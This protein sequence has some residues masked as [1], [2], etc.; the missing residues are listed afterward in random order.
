MTQGNPLKTPRRALVVICLNISALLHAGTPGETVSDV[1][2]NEY[3]TVEIGGRLWMRDNL[4]AENTAVGEP[5]GGA[6]YENE[7]ANCD[8]F[9]R[10]YTWYEIMNGSSEACAQGICP[11]GWHV[12][13]DEEW[14]ELEVALGVSPREADWSNSWRG[15]DQGTRMSVGG[16]S[17]FDF[18]EAGRSEGDGYFGWKHGTAYFWTSTEYADD[19]SKAWRRCLSNSK[20]TIGRWNTFPKTYGF[21]LRC[22]KDVEFDAAYVV[23]RV[24]ARCRLITS[25]HAD[26]HIVKKNPCNVM[27]NDGEYYFFAPESAVVKIDTATFTTFDKRGCE[28][29]LEAF[30][31]LAAPVLSAEPLKRMLESG[32][33][34]KDSA[35]DTVALSLTSGDITYE[36]F[37]EKHRW[38]VTSIRCSGGMDFQADYYYDYLQGIPTLRMVALEGDTTLSK[39]GYRFSN[40]TIN[41]PLPIRDLPSRSA[42]AVVRFRGGK[43]GVPVVEFGESHGLLRQVSIRDLRGRLVYSRT[44]SP[45]E[46]VFSL[47]EATE[48][49]QA[50]SQGVYVLQAHHGSLLAHRRFS[51]FK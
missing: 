12:P 44:V 48:A 51:V 37:V 3:R 4:N 22:I 7:P 10:L 35:G 6:C 11:E 27:E 43:E 31:V 2:G 20:A 21:S 36:Y 38:V 50:L 18:L 5:A 39:G 17:G 26:A 32:M 49:W 47:V 16:G 8:T 34:L 24:I 25:Y 33:Q 40:I 1:D 30:S 9:G 23:S 28:S 15:T 19:T 13:S 14:K 41:G 42:E 29:V 46:R 45:D